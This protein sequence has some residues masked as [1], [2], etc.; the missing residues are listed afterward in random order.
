MKTYQM[1]DVVRYPTMT[2]AQ[3]RET[4]LI[5]A[6]FQSGTINVAYVDLDRAVVGIA[7]PLGSRLPLAA[8]AA[9]RA[10]YF[11]ERREIGTLNI[12]GSG[13]IHSG[14]KSYAL[15]NLD[16]L[17]IGRGTAEIAFES[18]VPRANPAGFHQVPHQH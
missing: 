5:D 1:A 18:T 15:D 2:T 17:Y 7:A 3:I 8:D 10:Q 11:A 12:G 9:L 13:V 6:L 14:G 16:C 4:F